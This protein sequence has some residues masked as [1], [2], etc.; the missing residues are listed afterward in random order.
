M[1]FWLK[2]GQ[3]NLRRN[4]AYRNNE[5][6]AKNIII[7]IGDGMGIS[8]IT[9]GRIFKGQ[10]K[11]TTGEEYKLAFEKF[12]NT[13]FAKVRS[14]CFPLSLSRGMIEN[15]MISSGFFLPLPLYRR[16]LSFHAR[17][18]LLQTYNTDKQVPDSA[19]TATAIFS[20]VKCRY[21]VIGLDTK[22]SFN[23]CDERIDKASKVTTVADWAQQTGMATGELFPIP[24]SLYLIPSR[25]SS[26]SLLLHFLSSEQTNES[27]YGRVLRRVHV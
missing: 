14:I 9:A 11:G 4:L 25:F 13:G 3:E 6:R 2:S 22:A 17:L 26:F 15:F 27:R 24:Y 19:G 18:C 1:S 20:G 5:N 21:K 7:F 16:T 10:M 8:T 12:P 23:H